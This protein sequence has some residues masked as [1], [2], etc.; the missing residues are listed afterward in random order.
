MKYLNE[1]IDDEDN[2]RGAALQNG[3]Y[4]GIENNE[5]IFSKIAARTSFGRRETGENKAIE[6][7]K[8]QKFVDDQR[9]KAPSEMRN[10]MR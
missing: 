10:S 3:R 6:Y 8:W 7:E 1:W 5:I 9:G 2:P 4:F